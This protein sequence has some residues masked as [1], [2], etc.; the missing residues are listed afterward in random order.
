METS[1]IAAPC[2]ICIPT[3]LRV[4]EGLG[5]C[6]WD[7]PLLW[8]GKFWRKDG[9]VK[10]FELNFSHENT[11]VTTNC[12]TTINRKDWN[13]QK[14]KK[15]KILH[16]KTMKRQQDGRNSTFTIWDPG[17]SSDF[18]GIWTRHPCGSWRVLLGRWGFFWGGGDKNAGPRDY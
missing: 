6:G 16:L 18:I 2:P 8:Q 13:V 15:K 14:K 5:G 9:R 1:G 10:E 17:K 11:K 7:L 12:W 4:P 3:S